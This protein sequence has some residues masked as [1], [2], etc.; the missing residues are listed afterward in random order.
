[1]DRGCV[2]WTLLLIYALCLWAI[3]VCAAMYAELCDLAQA[4]FD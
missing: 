2:L 1:M 3:W 4:L